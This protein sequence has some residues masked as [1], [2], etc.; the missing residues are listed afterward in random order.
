VETTG[1]LPRLLPGEGHKIG[2]WT[3][4]ARRGDDA[5]IAHADEGRDALLAFQDRRKREHELVAFRA[6]QGK[7]AVASVLET[8][9]D[10]LY[11]PFLAVD[12]EGAG[13]FSR[14]ST[15]MALDDRGAIRTLRSVLEVAEVLEKAGLTWSPRAG[16][17]ANVGNGFRVMRIRG[18]R[19]LPPGERLDARGALVKLAP[20]LL[21]TERVGPE[22][23]RVVLPTRAPRRAS[24]DEVREA[25]DEATRV[26]ATK[27]DSRVAIVTDVGLHR[28]ENEDAAAQAEIPGGRVVVVC[29]G[30]SAAAHAATASRIAAD[31]V[32]SVVVEDSEDPH[33]A[34]VHGIARAHEELCEIQRH[35]GGIALGTTVIGAIVR[36]RKATIAWVGDSRA[37]VISPENAAILTQDHSWLAEALASGTPLEEALRSPWAHALTRCLGPLDGGEAWHAEP[38]VIDVELDEGSMLVLCTDGAWNY[39]P[40]AEQFAIAAGSSSSPAGVARALL[41]HSLLAGGQDNITVAA[42]AIE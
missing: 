10:P 11:G 31:T 32:V 25:L 3:V 39:A 38:E 40:S 29:D 41:S 22:I 2:R 42:I 19:P 9:D 1:P 24:I 23:L 27:D 35:R 12:L 28:D 37:Y 21:G 30:V 5:V 33:E 17:L 4:V 13:P 7:A 34:L 6:T 36:G 16:D 20:T 18:A 15:A 26:S 14:A 8:G